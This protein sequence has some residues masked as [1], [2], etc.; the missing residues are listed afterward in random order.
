MDQNGSLRHPP[1]EGRDHT[2]IPARTPSQAESANRDSATEAGKVPGSGE[3]GR[4]T[5]RPP[6]HSPRTKRPGPQ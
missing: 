5:T 3:G 2:V 4:E 1:A 6:E